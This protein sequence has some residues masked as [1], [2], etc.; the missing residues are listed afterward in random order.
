MKQGTVDSIH[1][2][3]QSAVTDSTQAT[4]RFLN[5]SGIQAKITRKVKA[6]CCEA[7]A[8]LAGSWVYGKEPKEI[9]RRHKYCSCTVSYDPGNGRVQNVH[10]KEW[11]RADETDKIKARKETGLEN[12]AERKS[13]VER[14]KAIAPTNKISTIRERINK[15][16]YST[17]LSHQQYLKH[18]D[19]TTQYQQYADSR[20]SA[21]NSMQS[22]IS[23]DEQ[24][25]QRLI[26]KYAGT[27]TP[28]TSKTGAVVS[29]EYI[30]AEIIVGRVWVNGAWVNTHRFAIHYGKNGAHIVPVRE[31]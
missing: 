25:A 6:N 21:G 28:A 23:V 29:K 19:G 26:E 15:G 16:E 14:R 8:A 9:Y 10:S 18:K 24:T 7:C 30:T 1:S 31:R 13:A 3:A 27:G 11:T 22:K 4:L 17:K 20:T 2:L 12:K 5:R